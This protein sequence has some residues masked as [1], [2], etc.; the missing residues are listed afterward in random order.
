[1]VDKD[2]FHLVALA[3]VKALAMFLENN[4]RN[5][6]VKK[7][8][9][10]RKKLLFSKFL[11]ICGEGS[12]FHQS[13]LIAIKKDL[14]TDGCNDWCSLAEDVWV[15]L[16]LRN[17]QTTHKL[18]ICTVYIIGENHGYSLGEQL[19]NFS[20]KLTA[21]SSGRPNDSFLILGDFNM[22]NL[23]WVPQPGESYLYPT[24]I[25]G[26]HQ[27][28]FFDNLKF[29]NLEQY[30]HLKNLNGRHLDLVFSNC[31]VTIEASSDPLVN[32]DPNHPA[33]IVTTHFT[34]LKPLTTIPRIKYPYEK[35][36][37]NAINDKLS[38]ID[39]PKTFSS[40]NIDEG[41]KKLY[42]TLYNLR[43]SYVPTK[44]IKVN[45]KYPSWYNPSLIKLLKEKHKFH[46]KYKKYKNIT[47]LNTFI[48]LRERAKIIEKE[49]YQVYIA[50]IENNI[51]ENPKS[52][53]SFIKN[54]K[55]SSV[56]PS[57]MSYGGDS[58]SS[59]YA[60]IK[61][62]LNEQ[63]H[64]FVKNKSTISNLL[65]CS[66]FLT[67]HMSK[68]YQV[69]VIYTD[70]SKAFDRIDH[71][72]LLLLRVYVNDI[73]GVQGRWVEFVKQDMRGNGLTLSDA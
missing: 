8:R 52:F 32:E 2:F 22:P 46:L 3:M 19:V 45:H 12:N 20:E 37:Y 26:W 50:K 5:V 15:V 49:C 67:E 40:K 69:D 64:G 53:W 63:Q 18:Y 24:N 39:W 31:E 28:T 61:S 51:V 36:N 30:N 9:T 65:L 41:V 16:T 56:Y 23:T 72:M 54:K 44:I 38:K 27:I 42:Q 35:A 21:K 14:I 33:L 70:Y 1:M 73:P 6:I 58:L 68:G 71:K 7:L 57:V 4:V 11:M 48:L 66:D 17:S 47:D 55:H 59:V 29:C 25:S 34:D 43:D 13:L 62:I 10:E 60:H